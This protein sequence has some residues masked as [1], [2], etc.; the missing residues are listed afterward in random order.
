MDAREEKPAPIKPFMAMMKSDKAAK[1]RLDMNERLG[2]PSAT[3]DPTAAREVSYFLPACLASPSLSPHLYTGEKKSCLPGP[4]RKPNQIQAL[5][6]MAGPQNMTTLWW[7][8]CYL[9]P[10][11][12]GIQEPWEGTPHMQTGEEGGHRQVLLFPAMSR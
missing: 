7:M 2:T 12:K 8:P 11:G 1:V 3:W 9:P 5:P 6:T 10:S 4:V